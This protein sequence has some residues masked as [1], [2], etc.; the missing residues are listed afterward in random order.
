MKTEIKAWSRERGAWSGGLKSEVG[1]DQ[2]L[3]PHGAGMVAGKDPTHLI[4]A[5][6]MENGLS[7]LAEED[8]VP[9]GVFQHGLYFQS[10][11]VKNMR[12]KVLT[13]WEALG[14]RIVAPLPLPCKNGYG[15]RSNRYFAEWLL[16]QD[17]AS[18]RVGSQVFYGE[19]W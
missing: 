4:S 18:G 2:D 13:L 8:L 9:S 5:Y 15:S 11:P 6:V 17:A 7:D 1:A 14:R 3:L 10:D 16:G 19:H 12:S